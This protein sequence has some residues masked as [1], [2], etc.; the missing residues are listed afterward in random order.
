MLGCSALT[1]A[2]A[3]AT[4]AAP[5]FGPDFVPSVADNMNGKYPISTTPGGKPGLFPERYADYPG[6][7]EYFDAYT[8][9]MTTLY[10]QVWWKA[11]APTPL[12]DEIVK[13]Y[14][15]KGMA[16]VGWEIDQVRRTAS[17]D[18]SVPITATYNHHYVSQMIGAGKKFTK[19]KLSGPDDPRAAKLKGASHGRVPW[20]QEQYIV[21]DEVE[22]AAP[23]SALPTHQQF[24]SANGGEYRKTYHGFAPGYALVVDSPTAFQVSP[25]QIDTW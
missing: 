5:N 9:A 18:V 13:K 17:G 6:G 21:E 24:S 25:M 2:F 10:S 4:H 15:G 22:G 11:L 1:L 8:P 12:P 14:S 20:E 16:I 3:P 7:V 23:R 19:V